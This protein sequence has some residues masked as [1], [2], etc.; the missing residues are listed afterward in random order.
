MRLSKFMASAGAIAAAATV[1]NFG[2]FYPN[3]GIMVFSA[4]EL[5]ASPFS[6]SI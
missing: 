3:L 2:F 1:K 5:S 6:L 4:N